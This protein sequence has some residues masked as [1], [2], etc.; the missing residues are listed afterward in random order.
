VDGNFT[1]DAEIDG[2]KFLMEGPVGDTEKPVPTRIEI[3]DGKK[4]VEA[5]SVEKV[6]A[7]YRDRVQKVI[8]NV[9]VAR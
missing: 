8:D 4:K 1:I 9:K 5:A 6:P 2:V 3:T 7:E